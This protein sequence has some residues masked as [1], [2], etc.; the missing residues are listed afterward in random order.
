VS[1]RGTIPHLPSPHPIGDLLPGV[2][3]DDEMM[4]RFV[5]AL[6]EVFAPVFSTLDNLTAYFDP[7][8]APADFVNWLANWVAL[9]LAE[10]WPADRRRALVARAVELHRWRGTKRGLS[11]LLETVTGGYVEVVDSG[12]CIGTEISGGPLPGYDQPGIRVRISVSDPSTLDLG[13][14]DGLVA[15]HKPAHIPHVLE[16]VQTG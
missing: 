8:L 11:A 3:A 15:L 9:P 13:R 10:E 16:V 1:T 14:L 5:S 2:F 7:A 12:G 4:Q 6:D